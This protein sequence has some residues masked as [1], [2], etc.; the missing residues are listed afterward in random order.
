[1]LTSAP[2]YSSTHRSFAPATFLRRFEATGFR[3]DTRFCARHIYC[4]LCR[5]GVPRSLFDLIRLCEEHGKAVL[6]DTRLPARIGG[7]C[8]GEALVVSAHL[9]RRQYYET[10]P[11]EL[12][13]ALSHSPRWTCLNAHIEGWRY[14]RATFLEAVARQVGQMF[15]AQY[16]AENHDRVND[17]RIEER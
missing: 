13:H 6:P 17:S 16:A 1:M 2:V 15:L 12:V 5:N 9:S 7:F 4:D 10:I 14:D 3:A 11:H 8:D